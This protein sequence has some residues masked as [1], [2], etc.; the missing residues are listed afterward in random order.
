[1]INWDHPSPPSLDLQYFGAAPGD[2]IVVGIA[3]PSASASVARST[4]PANTFTKVNSLS[5]LVADT[6]YFANNVLYVRL[7][8]TL[9]AKDVTKAHSGNPFH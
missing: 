4:Y 2:W 3:F 9:A 8:N 7:E 1:M 5:E 6:Y